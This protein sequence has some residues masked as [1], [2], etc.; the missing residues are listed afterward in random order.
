MLYPPQNRR[1]RH[2]DAAFTHHG[3]QVAKAQFEAQVPADAQDH[4]LLVEGPPFEQLF[5]RHE[6]W[7]LFIIAQCDCV[8]TRALSAA[9]RAFCN[10]TDMSAQPGSP[11]RVAQFDENSGTQ[12]DSSPCA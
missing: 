10:T 7:H 1:V 9:F 6:S 4:D 12:T 2:A 8:C 11:D 5:Y 3:D